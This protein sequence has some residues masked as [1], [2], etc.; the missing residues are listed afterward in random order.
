MT[1]FSQILNVVSLIP[2]GK[3]TTYGEISRFLNLNNPRIVG[4]ALHT[5]TDPV[6]YRCHRVVKK[7]GVLASGYVFGGEKVQK[8]KLEQEGIKFKSGKV[9]I[10]KYLFK[11]SDK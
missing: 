9:D 1:I 4:F 8:R 2:K 6:K 11:L 7:D 10:E 3:I 5:N